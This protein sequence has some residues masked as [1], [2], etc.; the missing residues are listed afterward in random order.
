MFTRHRAYRKL[1]GPWYKPWSN[2]WFWWWGRETLSLH[3][4]ATGILLGFVW[5]NPEMYAEAWP[6]AASVGYFSGA[7]VLS[8]FAWSFIRSYAKKKG[9]DIT[10]P[11]GSDRPGES[12]PDLIPNSMPDDYDK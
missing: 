5:Q 10:L 6:L 3:P 11:G 8:L 9:I 12:P 2:Q 7:G 1:S 4:I